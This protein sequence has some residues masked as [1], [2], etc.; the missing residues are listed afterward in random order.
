MITENP[1]YLKL[2]V[3]GITN[4][5][6]KC[7]EFTPISA[8]F[9]MTY[10]HSTVLFTRLYNFENKSVSSIY[11]VSFIFYYTI[12]SFFNCC[13]NTKIFLCCIIILNHL[14]FFSFI[15]VFSP[16]AVGKFTASGQLTP[17]CGLFGGSAAHRYTVNLGGSA[18]CEQ[19]AEW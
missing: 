7:I 14:E 3:S 18:A 11:Y 16:F 4:G 1:T 13:K 12:T 9:R 15:L 10:S 5:I 2:L 19:A 6:N 8:N 17:L